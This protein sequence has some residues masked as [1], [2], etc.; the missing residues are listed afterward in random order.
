MKIVVTGTA[1]FI[2]NAVAQHL[3]DVGHTKLGE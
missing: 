2:G 1:G 3:A